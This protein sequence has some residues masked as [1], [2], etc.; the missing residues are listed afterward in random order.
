[1][2]DGEEILKSCAMPPGE[3]AEADPFSGVQSW[4]PLR[5]SPAR[6]FAS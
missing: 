6:R 5:A 3:R 1:M 2:S 4:V